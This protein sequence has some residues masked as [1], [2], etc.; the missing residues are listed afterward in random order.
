MQVSLAIAFCHQSLR[1]SAMEYA[2]KK[3]TLLTIAVTFALYMGACTAEGWNI[4]G[5]SITINATVI[6]K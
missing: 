3:R 4:S 6:Q 1:T 2:M 5:N